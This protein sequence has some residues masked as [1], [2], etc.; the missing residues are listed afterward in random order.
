MQLVDGS[1]EEHRDAISK[2]REL[3]RWP[4]HCRPT[5]RALQNLIA[6]GIAKEDVL[7]GVLEHLQRGSPIYAIT[8]E[9]SGLTAY[10]FL[11]CF[12]QSIQLYVKV[13]VPPATCEMREQLILISAHVPQFPVKEKAK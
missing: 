11:P 5:K 7:D 1:S 10:V 4:H 12:I 2:I 6:L 13:Q 3:A 8:Q 9:E